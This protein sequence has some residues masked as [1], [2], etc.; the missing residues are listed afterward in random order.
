[1]H[2]NPFFSRSLTKMNLMTS[3]I[4][5]WDKLP[6]LDSSNSHKW[7]VKVLIEIIKSKIGN[8]F[9]FL[10]TFTAIANFL[11]VTYS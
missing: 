3:S 5:T 1:M 2:E 4:C 9:N 6:F 7:S 8:S 11:L 10:T